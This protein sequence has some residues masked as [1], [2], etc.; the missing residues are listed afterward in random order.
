MANCLKEGWIGKFAQRYYILK[1]ATEGFISC[2]EGAEALKIS[3]RH[4]K[5][6]KKK[7]QKLGQKALIRGNRGLT[8]PNPYPQEIKQ[9]VLR[10]FRSPISQFQRLSLHRYPKRRAWYQAL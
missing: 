4:L 2:K 8:P 5:R 6:L 10:L 3:E 9:E 1:Q 7:S